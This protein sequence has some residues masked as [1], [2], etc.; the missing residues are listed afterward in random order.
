MTDRG[1]FGMPSVFNP[2]SKTCQGCPGSSQCRDRAL[3]ALERVRGTIRVEHLIMEF[4][5]EFVQPAAALTLEQESVVASMPAKIMERL[6]GLLLAR[7]DRKA[8][9]ALLHGINPFPERGAKHM[10]LAGQLLLAGGFTK[11]Q[12]RKEC[13]QRFGWTEGTA[14]SQVS[15]AI[16][17]LRGLGLTTEHGDRVSPAGSQPQH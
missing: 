4:R 8:S 9:V 17:L 12:F 11:S 15:Q 1:C 2:A 10:H 6:R 5:T 3:D 7:F 13:E 14:F 16:A